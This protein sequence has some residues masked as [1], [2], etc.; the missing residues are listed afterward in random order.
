MNPRLNDFQFLV[1]NDVVTLGGL[2][3]LDLLNAMLLAQGYLLY[4]VSVKLR[5]FCDGLYAKISWEGT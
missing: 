5:S 1:A 2:E 4:C 3:A